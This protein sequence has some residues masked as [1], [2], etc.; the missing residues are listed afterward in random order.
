MRK[1]CS[2]E[3]FEKV[4]IYSKKKQKIYR[5]RDE[6]QRKIFINEI[7]ETPEDQ[8]VFLDESGIDTFLCREYGRA[9]KEEKIVE[10]VSEKRFE[11]QSIIAGLC[12]KN[13][14]T[15]F[16]YHGTFDANLFNFLLEKC[17]FR[18]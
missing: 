13:T 10:E 3:S 15:P 7:R 16:G 6:S 14:L 12:G 1:R 5:E 4:R 2:G 18:A 8:L 9:K 11:R 17:W